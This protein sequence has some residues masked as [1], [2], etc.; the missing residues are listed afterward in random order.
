MEY[1]IIVHSA[2][3][4]GYWSEAPALPGCFSQGETVEEA[5]KNMKMA[6]KSHIKALKQDKQRIPEEY[7]FIISKVKVA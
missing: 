3:E 2:E 4:G 7:D 1:I 6:M 5:I